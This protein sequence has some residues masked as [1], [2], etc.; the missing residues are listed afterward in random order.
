[1]AKLRGQRCITAG[2][3]SGGVLVALGLKNLLTLFCAELADGTVNQ[4]DQ[5]G[6]GQ[7]PDTGPQGPGEKVIEAQIAAN[8]RVGR[9]GHVHLVIADE[10]ANQR[11]GDAAALA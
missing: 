6:V 4:A 11:G 9:L 5:R 8:V 3:G 1:M 7:E 10:P 2:Q